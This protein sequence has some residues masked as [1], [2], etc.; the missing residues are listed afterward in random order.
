MRKP[1]ANF[2]EPGHAHELTFSCYGR[3]PLLKPE[4][5]CEWLAAAIDQARRAFDSAVWAWV[6]M[7][8]HAHVLVFPRSA[9]YD[10]AM[11]RQRTKGS[12]ARPAIAFMKAHAPGMVAT[13][14][15][16]TRPA[17]QAGVLTVWW[18]PRSEDHPREA[19]LSMT[20]DLHAN[21]VRRGF[22]GRPRDWHLSS[23]A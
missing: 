5:T 22:A 15:P 18:R 13:D 10:I 8:D 6:S 1:R 19:L 16:P 3:F 12:V 17:F 2:N 7:P 23:V 14:H 21:P 20:D 4:R 11:I 9:P